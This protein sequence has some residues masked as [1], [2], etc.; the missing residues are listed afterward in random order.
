LSF[1]TLIS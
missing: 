1:E